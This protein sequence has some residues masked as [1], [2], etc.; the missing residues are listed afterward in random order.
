MQ[1]RIDA[2]QDRRIGNTPDRMVMQARANAGQG[3]CMTGR[4]MDA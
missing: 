1:D 3:G 4:I 2:C